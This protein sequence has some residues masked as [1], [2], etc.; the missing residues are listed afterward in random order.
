MTVTRGDLQTLDDEQLLNDTVMD[1]YIKVY[2]HER[3]YKRKDI[4]TCMF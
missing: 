1:F 4:D 2:V 3:T